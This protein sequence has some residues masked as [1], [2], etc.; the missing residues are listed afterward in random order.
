MLLARNSFMAQCKSLNK[1]PK[2]LQRGRGVSTLVPSSLW[3]RIELSG[4]PWTAEGLRC[5]SNFSGLQPQAAEEP[6]GQLPPLS[7]PLLKEELLAVTFQHV[8]PLL[9]TAVHAHCSALTEQFQRDK[10][11]RPSAAYCPASLWAPRSLHV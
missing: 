5:R 11:W 8:W 2:T 1:L 10:T 6:L 7:S 4:S 3:A 9:N